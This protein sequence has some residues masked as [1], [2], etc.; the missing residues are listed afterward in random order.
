MGIGCGPAGILWSI[1]VAGRVARH[2]S[3][4]AAKRDVAGDLCGRAAT[5]F[6]SGLRRC[7]P[8]RPP[9]IP[10]PSS[11]TALPAR[12]ATKPRPSR[13]HPRACLRTLQPVQRGCAAAGAGCR[14]RH[15]S[16]PGAHPARAASGLGAAPRRRS[17]PIPNSPE[18]LRASSDIAAAEWRPS[19][20]CPDEFGVTHVQ[21]LS[22]CGPVRGRGRARGQLPRTAMRSSA[23]ACSR[24]RWPST[25]PASPTNCRCRRSP[26]S[27]PATILRSRN[28]TSPANI[29]NASPRISPSR[30]RRPGR[31]STRPAGR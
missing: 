4:V 9:P 14:A 18:V 10:S 29:P 8:M 13:S 16:W 15:R 12:R 28:S 30:L 20:S 11:A 22:L 26:C 7:G 3:A 24:R 17:P 19:P 27:R 21:P 31:I 23:T 1:R 25:I 5:S 6:S 2:A